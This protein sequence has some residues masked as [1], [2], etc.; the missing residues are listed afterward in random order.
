MKVD[1]TVRVAA[2]ATLLAP[3]LVGSAR[4]QFGIGMSLP[5]NDF[6]WTWG[7]QRTGGMI[8]DF[9]VSGA[10]AGFRCDLTGKLRL[11]SMSGREI[12]ALE[13]QLR[14]SIFFVRNAANA[15][16]ALDLRGELDWATLECVQPKP[17]E[18]DA[19]KRA[20]REAKALEKAARE[21]ERR[22]ARQQREDQ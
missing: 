5:D 4:A 21:R 20:E 14:G 13:D 1:E 12:R 17:R 2:F 10:E 15:M 22:R 7:D 9:S 11:G 8:E 3:L 16:N 6:T 19:E 18:A